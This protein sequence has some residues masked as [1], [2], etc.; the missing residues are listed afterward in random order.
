MPSPTKMHK[1]TWATPQARYATLFGLLGL[2]ALLQLSIRRMT[3]TI[4]HRMSYVHYL[5]IDS[6][7]RLPPIEDPNSGR[8]CDPTWDQIRA[9]LLRVDGEVVRTIFVGQSAPSSDMPFDGNG[10]QIGKELDGPGYFLH[11]YMP[12]NHRVYVLIDE[13]KPADEGRM[14]N[15]GQPVTGNAQE[16]V[17]LA[18]VL[19]AGEY[20]FETGQLDPSLTWISAEY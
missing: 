13:T 4:A 2:A 6:I 5:F 1:L 8:I 11:I 14:F 15:N 9:A 17:S 20:F 12:E 3:F 16:S 19:K 10:A 7:W 18:W